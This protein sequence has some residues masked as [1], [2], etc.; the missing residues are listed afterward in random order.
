MGYAYRGTIRRTRLMYQ[1]HSH[2]RHSMPDHLPITPSGSV[3][4]V[5]PYSPATGF[6]QAVFSM[7][8]TK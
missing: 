6:Q 3:T 1:S 7:E 5:G 4:P 2:H 8:I